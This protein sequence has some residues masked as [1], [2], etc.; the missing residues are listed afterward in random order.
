MI[1][2]EQVEHIG[3]LARIGLAE[4]ELKKFGED[5][6]LILRYVEKLQEANTD[7]VEPTSNIIGVENI[8]REDVETQFELQKNKAKSLEDIEAADGHQELLK[9]E[10]TAANLIKMA[11]DKEN[12]WV[13]VKSIL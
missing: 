10:E 4:D 13:R 7:D 2:Q 9:K 6:S 3:K 8:V 11:P 12:G 5:L 1:L